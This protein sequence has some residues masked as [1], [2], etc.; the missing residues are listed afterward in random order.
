MS[1]VF[2]AMEEALSSALDVKVGDIV[3][4]EV[5]TI[6]DNKQIIVG[7]IDA[8]LEGVI[9]AK[10]LSAQP[11]EHLEDIVNIGDVLDLVVISTIKD[12]ENGHYL[13]SKRRVDARRIWEELETKFNQGELVEGK[14]TGVVKG[15]L[16]VDLGVRAFVPASLVAERFIKDLSSLKDQTLVFKISECVPAENKLILSRKAVLEQ[17]TAKKIE[18]AF[19]HLE[20]DAVVEGTVSRLTNF[21]AFIDLG[22][23]D[24]LVHVSQ[25][26]HEHVKNPA[27]KLEI[28]QKVTVKITGLDKE[29]NRVSLSIKETIPTPWEIASQ[30][31]SLNQSVKGIVKR[32]V[33]FG[34]FVEIMPGVEGLLHVS[35]IAHEHVVSPQ[36]VLEIGQ[37]VDVKIIE[38]RL[39]DQRIALSMKALIEKPVEDDQEVENTQEDTYDINDENTT[40]TLGDVLGEQLQL[41]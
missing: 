2:N 20:L 23:V 37:E 30:E 40:V 25:I 14:V 4:G 35:Q 28:G 17:E 39:A 9:P 31:L 21:G 29:N 33:D 15:G 32:L 6:Q 41:N 26:A 7:I 13:L 38:L 10:E 3:K 27:D 19:S 12:K 18:E 16:I 36:A 22:G 8:G 34:A 11:V 5:L 24:G 1:E